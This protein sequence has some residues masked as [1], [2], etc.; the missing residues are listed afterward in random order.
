[1]I[2]ISYCYRKSG[3]FHV[4][5]IHLDSARFYL[6]KYIDLVEKSDIK[7]KYGKLDG[8][9]GNLGWQLF[10]EGK[11]KEGI[12]EVQRSKDYLDSM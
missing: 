12:Y 8:A 10:A 9:Y 7:D 1:M 5:S 11:A 4:K 6:R 3:F 2:N